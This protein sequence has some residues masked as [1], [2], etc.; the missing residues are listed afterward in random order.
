MVLHE[1][2]AKHKFTLLSW[3]GDGGV[4][5]AD[6]PR[7][8]APLDFAVTA[9]KGVAEK[10]AVW[11]MESADRNVLRLRI[12]LHWA[13]DI[14]TYN[15]PGYWSSDHLNLFIKYEREIGLSGTVAVTDTVFE[16]LSPPCQR[17]FSHS[18]ERPLG[19]ISK[20]SLPASRERGRD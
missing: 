2:L 4:Y 6:P 14:Y 9:A 1:E 5:H 10:T 3:K 20:D 19:L 13:P 17:L 12:S 15:E 8:S 18:L 11:R 16:N 7:G